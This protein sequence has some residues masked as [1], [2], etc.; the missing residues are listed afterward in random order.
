ML[1]K[2]V[3]L[4]FG[5]RNLLI[6]VLGIEAV[7]YKGYWGL[8]FCDFIVEQVFADFRDLI[9]VIELFEK[10]FWGILISLADLGD[11]G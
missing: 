11:F 8:R 2:V 10:W 5:E 9:H 7:T 6:K 4:S 3:I 1:Y